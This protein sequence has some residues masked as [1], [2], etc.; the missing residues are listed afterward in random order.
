ML[1]SHRLSE[2]GSV[3][4]FLQIKSLTLRKV[5]QLAGSNTW[6]C[7][8][9]K[10][11]LWVAIFSVL[12][13]MFFVLISMFQGLQMLVTSAQSPYLFSY[14]FLFLPVLVCSDSGNRM[15]QTEWL[16]KQEL[17]FSL[18]WKLEVQDRGVSRLGFSW[19]C[20]LW[21]ADGR[22]LTVSS[23]GLFFLC[24]HSCISSY[25]DTSPIGLGSLPNDLS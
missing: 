16:N 19:G 18:F 12:R 9:L 8:N 10:S 23:D 3:I 6:V 2:V 17:I 11:I 1:H 7:L 14:H 13:T 4:S 15:P 20:F 25:K 21:L 22:L 24:V 5:M